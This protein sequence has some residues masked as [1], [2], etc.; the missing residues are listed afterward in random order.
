MIFM[1]LMDFLK[2][3]LTISAWNGQKTVAIKFFKQARVYIKDV[4]ISK[5][6]SAFCAT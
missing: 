4:M 3:L 1:G 5:S 6:T 2:F